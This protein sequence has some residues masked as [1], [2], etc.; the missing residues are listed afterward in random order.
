ME[1]DSSSFFEITIGGKKQGRIFFELFS[2]V[3]PKT[4]EKYVFP[5]RCY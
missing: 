2:H 5:K 1:A 3:V 4:A